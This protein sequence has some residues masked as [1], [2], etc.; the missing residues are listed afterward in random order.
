MNDSVATLKVLLAESLDPRLNSIA[1]NPNASDI[2]KLLA[3]LQAPDHEIPLLI[4]MDV[5]RKDYYD[6]NE[7]SVYEVGIAWID[8][9][10]LLN[11]IAGDN[12]QGWHRYIDSKLF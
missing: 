9:N 2:D 10:M 12:G 4:A 1:S 11:K 8:V 5:E 7:K 6:D 3:L